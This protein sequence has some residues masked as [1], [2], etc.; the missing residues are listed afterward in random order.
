MSWDFLNEA[1]GGFQSAYEWWNQ[2]GPGAGETSPPP[3]GGVY[4][5]S[6]NPYQAGSPGGSGIM[7]YLPIMILA[8]VAVLIVVIVKK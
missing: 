2:E 8:V 4:F 3:S 6:G 7:G 1:W 5:T